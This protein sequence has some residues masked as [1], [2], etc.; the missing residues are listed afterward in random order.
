MITWY[1]GLDNKT[2]YD[3]KISDIKG[4]Y[5][6]TFDYNNF[7]SDILDDILD[8]KIKK[9]KGEIFHESNIFD[10]VKSLI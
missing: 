2:D 10:L 5:F 6:T 1:N 9:N 4:K 3:A 8:A 7:T